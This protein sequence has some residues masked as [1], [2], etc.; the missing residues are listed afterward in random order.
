MRTLKT[1]TKQRGGAEEG[2]GADGGGGVV[3][4]V[5]FCQQ[6]VLDVGA[7]MI[8]VVCHQTTRYATP[9][10]VR[11]E[12]EKTQLMPCAGIFGGSCISI[13]FVAARVLS[14]QNTAFVSIHFLSRLKTCFVAT[15]TC[16]SRQ[17]F[18]RQFQNYVC[19]DM[20]TFVATKHAFVA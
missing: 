2:R 17:T 7:R 12:Q 9:V 8:E 11:N 14:R 16:L 13:I 15:N 4:I 10:P 20:H 3:Y 1:K 19:R 6:V 5:S 18:S